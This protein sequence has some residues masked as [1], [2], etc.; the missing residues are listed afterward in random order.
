[1][2]LVR[3]RGHFLQGGNAI[4]GG[5]D[6]VF[7]KYPRGPVLARPHLA[8][9]GVSLVHSGQCLALKSGDGALRQRSD[10]PRTSLLQCYRHKLDAVMNPESSIA[11]IQ[12]FDFACQFRVSRVSIDT[13]FVS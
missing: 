8:L 5:S 10:L 13:E 12:A 11:L 9:V 6:S 2:L 4:I 1:L 3:R 7:E